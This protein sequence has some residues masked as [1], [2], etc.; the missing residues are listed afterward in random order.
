MNL[1]LVQ[2]I[3]CAEIVALVVVVI[4]MVTSPFDRVGYLEYVAV[5]AVILALG[6]VHEWLHIRK[7]RELGLQVTIEPYYAVIKVDIGEKFSKRRFRDFTPSMKKTYHQ[8]AIQPYLFLVPLGIL[9]FLVP[10]MLISGDV[11]TNSPL[12][13]SLMT[14]GVNVVIWH[15]AN[16]PLEYVVK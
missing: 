16:L 5:I 6:A 1:R 13:S 10:I 15:G 7:A 14:I 8:I 3:T 11:V 9:C 2:W 12:W 4:T